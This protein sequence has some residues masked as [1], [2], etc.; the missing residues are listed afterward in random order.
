MPEVSAELID[1]I[2]DAVVYNHKGSYL[3][4]KRISTYYPYVQNEFSSFLTQ[5][6]TPISQKSLYKNLLKLDVSNLSGLPIE[7]DSDGN[8]FIQLTPEQ[9]ENVSNVEC[10]IMPY[11]EGGDESV[12]LE[13]T[14]FV[15]LRSNTHIKRDWNSGIFTENFSWGGRPTIDGHKISMNLITEKILPSNNVETDEEVFRDYYEI[16]IYWSGK[17]EVTDEDGNKRIKRFQDICNLPVAY[18]WATKNRVISGVGSDVE[19]VP[20]RQMKFSLEPGDSSNIY[21]A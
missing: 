7:E 11:V 15:V 8:G 17:R 4:A 13:N 20:V 10:V 12:G 6:A 16:P 14:G 3:R 1:A 21:I 18:E 9:L 19:N 5:K 2:D